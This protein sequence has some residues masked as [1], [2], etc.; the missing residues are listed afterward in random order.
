[1]LFC[2]RN[3]FGHIGFDCFN[4]A[5]HGG[6][7]IALAPKADPASHHGAELAECHIGGSASVHACQIAA[8]CKRLHKEAYVKP[9][10]M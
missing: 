8:L 6:D 1:M 4:A 10:V 5:L 3:E 7:G 2:K 9:E